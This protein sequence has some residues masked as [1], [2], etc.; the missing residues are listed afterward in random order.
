M[1]NNILAAIAQNRRRHAE[2]SAQK[3]PILTLSMYGPE[4][5]LP[6]RYHFQEMIKKLVNTSLC[7]G[8]IIKVIS[9][10]LFVL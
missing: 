10:I 7:K 5:R 8:I 2:Q 1:Y 9:L 6:S 4:Q 3:L